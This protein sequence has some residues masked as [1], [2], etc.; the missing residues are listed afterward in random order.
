MSLTLASWN[1]NSVRA[2]AGLVAG[3]M[4]RHPDCALLG[5]QEIKCTESQ[6]PT[7]FAQ[8]GHRTAVKGQKA[9]NGVAILGRQDMVVVQDHLAAFVDSTTQDG[10]PAARYLEVESAGIHM[11]S[12]YVPNGNSGG[13]AGL[14]TKLSFLEAL[15]ARAKALLDKHVPF[16]LMGDFNICP[17]PLDHA[18]GTLAPEDAL[19]LPSVQAAY[20]RLANLGLTDAYRALHPQ[21]AGYTFWDYQGGA[22]KRG[23]GLRID[24]ALLSPRLADRL[25]SAEVDA[26]QRDTTLGGEKPEKPSDHAPLVVK[27]R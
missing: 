21:E 10:S 3:W 19:L 15:A 16:A 17:T 24:M 12:L 5:L 22:R 1:I 11:A 2:R 23:A 14:A 18:P 25:E 9:Y 13:E 4:D 20:R 6:F 8:S 27:L 26:K 7:T